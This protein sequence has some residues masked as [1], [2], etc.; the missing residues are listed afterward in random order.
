M[1]GYRMSLVISFVL[2]LKG[3]TA[4]SHVFPL[5]LLRKVPRQMGSWRDLD[6]C[7]K[8]WNTHDFVFC[9]VR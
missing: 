2:E 6:E 1:E 5:L 4:Y 3:P 8:R 9:L 7:G